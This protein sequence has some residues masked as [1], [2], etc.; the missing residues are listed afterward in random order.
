MGELEDLYQSALLEH[1]RSPR[2]FGSLP[3]A[4]HQAEV[5]NPLC[6]DRIG[7]SLHI[8]GD[9]IL[10][11][12]FQGEGCIL[13]KSSAS[14]LT[15]AVTGRTR[16]EAEDLQRRFDALLLGP[17]EAVDRLCEELGP[18]AAFSEVRTFP[19]RIR[20]ATLPWRTLREALGRS[21]QEKP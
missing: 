17:P 16:G 8:E 11:A 9:R 20:C 21:E 19:T 13:S 6:G 10:A 3:E 5:L 7:L 4:T 2:N 1:S 14:M 18:L 12:S 15:E